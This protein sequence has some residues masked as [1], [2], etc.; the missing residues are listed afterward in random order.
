MRANL[1]DETTDDTLKNKII[2][3]IGDMTEEQK[4]LAVKLLRQWLSEEVS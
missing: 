3:T 1:A 4:E 2:L